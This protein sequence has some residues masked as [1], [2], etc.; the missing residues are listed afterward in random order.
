MGGSCKIIE[1][2]EVTLAML[3]LYARLLQDSRH[4]QVVKF[5]D[6]P[7]LHRS[8]TDWPMASGPYRPT[9][10]RSWQAAS[11]LRTPHLRATDDLLLEMMKSS[12]VQFR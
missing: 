11:A 5:A 8:F 10:F 6:K 9:S 1:G 12:V 4:G 3:Y 7:M 2:E